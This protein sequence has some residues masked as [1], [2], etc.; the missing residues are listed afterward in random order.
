LLRYFSFFSGDALAAPTH[1]YYGGAS[2]IRSDY[3]RAGI[4]DYTKPMLELPGSI[5][6]KSNIN[7]GGRGTFSRE[8]GISI[9]GDVINHGKRDYWSP[10]K[11]Y[12]YH[13]TL[14]K[15][16]NTLEAQLARVLMKSIVANNGKFNADHFRKAYIDFMTTPGSHNDAY[17]STCHRMFFRNLKLR[18]L[19]PE[20][21]P[22]NDQHNVDTIDGLV[23][24][25]IAAMTASNEE[26]A[27]NIAAATAAVTR[28]S[29]QLEGVSRAWGKLVYNS[30][31]DES[32]ENM[33]AHL[34]ECAKEA[35]L[36]KAPSA[37]GADQMTY[38][39][40]IAMYQ[41][42]RCFSYPLNYAYFSFFSFLVPA[43]CHHHSRRH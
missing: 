1:W 9:V 31:T 42:L 19:P 34:M 12:H 20:D 43:T 35:G 17:A 23:L 18:N 38:V 13:A 39:P 33:N 25:T 8:N 14:Q 15:G 4:T 21:C 11:S 32:D 3:G 30:L 27:G 22:D 26:E 41:Y 10:K 28:R 6:N 2:Q 37:R 7:G 36:R 40:C 16:E 5:M 24:P 29:S